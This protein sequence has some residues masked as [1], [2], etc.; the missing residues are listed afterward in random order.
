MDS[1]F[2]AATS[3]SISRSLLEVRK[4]MSADVPMDITEKQSALGVG[5]LLSLLFA[6]SLG[7]LGALIVVPK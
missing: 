5:S 4:I 2:K 6:I 1:N 3:E 7:A